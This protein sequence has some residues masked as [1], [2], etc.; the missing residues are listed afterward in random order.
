MA[1][2][3][4]AFL[5]FAGHARADGPFKHLQA[6]FTQA[7]YGVRSVPHLFG[8]V[9]F[10]PNGD[11]VV[12]NCQP[13]GPEPLYRFDSTATLPAVHDTFNLHP[14][15]I[16][17]SRQAGCGLTDH[18]DGE[19]YSNTTSGV[20]ELNASTGQLMN[21]PFGPSGRGLGITVDPQ[22]GNLT[23][24]EIDGT[25]GWVNPTLTMS[26]TISTVTSGIAGIDQIAYDPTGNFLFLSDT[27]NNRL[28]ILR[29]N[30]SLVQYVRLTKRSIPDGV[31]FHAKPSFVVT[32]NNDGTITRFDFPN[33]D[34]TQP[35]TQSVFASGGFRGDNVQVASNGCMYLTQ[36]GT[37]YADGTV[38]TTTAG[39][40]GTTWT[41]NS[42]VQICGGF[43]PG[44]GVPSA[45]PP[46]LRPPPTLSGFK[47]APRAFFPASKGSSIART[48]TAVS[49]RDSEAATTTFTV[50]E[51]MTGVLRGGKCVATSSRRL[52]LLYPPCHRAIVLGSFS[53]QDH[54]GANRFNFTGRVRGR[55]LKPGRYTL[56][57]IAK[58][59]KFTSTPV[60]AT[61]RIMSRK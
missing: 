55:T 41:T 6:P 35:P 31:A 52:K 26:G 59:G 7:L 33:N 47:L 5:L 42:L 20:V 10:A 16:E 18:P 48:G 4:L 53:H 14:S 12:D 19:L 61:F 32:N 15:S 38:K 44:S 39:P 3:G 45:A 27:A 36:D 51:K 34:Y 28:I 25:I 50:L 46:V 2:L 13:F 58:F 17:T 54:V 57:A 49:Y 30:G 60:Q 40:G 11:P 22:S 8:G 1:T 43:V 24:V 56:R 23:F 29:R 9:A 21:G 37:R